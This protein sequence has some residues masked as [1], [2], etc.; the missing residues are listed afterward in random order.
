MPCGSTH[1]VTENRQ[2]RMKPDIDSLG[3]EFRENGRWPTGL[4]YGDF[5]RT[6]ACLKRKMLKSTPLGRARRPLLITW[7]V[8]KKGERPNAGLN[9]EKR[10]K[11]AEFNSSSDNSERERR[12]PG[13]KNRIIGFS[14]KLI[15]R[16][17]P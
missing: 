6:S 9:R 12:W 14:V 15:R 8:D 10:D 13:P 1:W 3:R 5:A 11:G 7:C 16:A 4:G 2:S 17:D